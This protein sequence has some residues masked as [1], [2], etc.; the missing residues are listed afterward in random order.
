MLKLSRT[1]EEKDE[2][3]LMDAEL[4]AI[5]GAVKAVCRHHHGGFG[6]FGGF[7]G[8]YG[9]YPYGYP[10]VTAPVTLAEPATT[11]VAAEP[12]VTAVA[13]EPIIAAEPVTAA[14]AAEPL[15]LAEPVGLGCYGFGRR[16]RH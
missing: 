7:E 16:R 9:G 4:A 2:I 10:V 3:E 12:A 1:L 5:H 8:F 13:A 11:F 6:G 15:V 14:V